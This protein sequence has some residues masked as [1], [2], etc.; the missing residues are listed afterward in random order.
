MNIQI[1]TTNTELIVVPAVDSF[2]YDKEMSPGIQ[3][4]KCFVLQDWGKRSLNI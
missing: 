3:S 4:V 1:S 2:F